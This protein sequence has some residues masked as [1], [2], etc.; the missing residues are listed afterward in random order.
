MD[1]AMLIGFT[2]QRGGM[3]DAQLD[4]V[5][6]M[7]IG[8]GKRNEMRAPVV[9][10]VHGD[11]IGADAEFD[12]L[13]A[14]VGIHRTKRPCTMNGEAEHPF[15]AYTDAQTIAEPTNPMAR[16]RAIASTCDVLIACPP[17]KEE[18]KRSGTWAT[19]RY[20]RKYGKR[21]WVIAPDGSIHMTDGT[22]IRRL[23]DA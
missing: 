8:W 21:V 11:C 18:L 4:E 10:A 15:R 6:G 13:C 7:L 5:R 3:S 2:G 9:T 19:I 12:Q 1:E 14:E 23:T 17:T 16:N 20:G 22:P